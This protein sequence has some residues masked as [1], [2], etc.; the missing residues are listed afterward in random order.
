MIK[1]KDIYPDLLIIL[2]WI[3]ITLVFVTSH[4]LENSPIRTVFGIP[5]VLF[6][7]GYVLVA[8]LFP[9]RGDLD[10]IERMALS[11][12]MS[13]AIVPLLGLLLSFTVG[14]R[15]AS[16]VATI[17]IYS[18][19]LIVVAIYRRKKLSKEERFSI[20]PYKIYRII[21]DGIKPKGRI[22]AVLSV[23]LI[24]TIVATTCVVYY[25][26]ESPKLGE[27]FT[28]FYVLDENG[29]ADN[30]TTNLKLGNPATYIVGISN[31]EHEST[32]YTLQV[33]L[34]KRV[35]TS[36]EIFNGH[37]ETW[38][39]RIIVEPDREGADLMLEFLLFKGGDTTV[40][41]RSLHLWV[42]ST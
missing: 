37:G 35:L 40:P 29:K 4:G 34:D 8:S 22:D 12:G 7:P 3:M 5:M 24:S 14:I 33:L 23:I 21:V 16:V 36:K 2:I 38:E 10:N 26:I 6:I 1:T 17:V 27:K 15:L 42:N 30:Y 9:A 11:V 31:N 13:I 32:N 41:Y 19:F 25:V 18:T 28:E 20:E 39:D